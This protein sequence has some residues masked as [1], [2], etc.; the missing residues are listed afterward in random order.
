LRALHGHLTS[1]LRTAS[2]L[3][4][5]PCRFSETPVTEHLLPEA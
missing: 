2:R 3:R 5:R 1:P 4:R